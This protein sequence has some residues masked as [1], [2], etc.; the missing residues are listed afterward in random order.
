LGGRGGLKLIR[1]MKGWKS[2]NGWGGEEEEPELKQRWLN[3]CRKNGVK[4]LNEEM[5]R[6]N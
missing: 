3:P 1:G 5:P 4:E 6:R 2:A